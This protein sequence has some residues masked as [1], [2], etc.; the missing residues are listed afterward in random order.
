MTQRTIE[1]YHL[2]TNM[3]TIVVPIQIVSLLV[4]SAS[5]PDSPRTVEDVLLKIMSNMDVQ[6][7]KTSTGNWHC[8]Q[9]VK[10]VDHTLICH[11]RA[12]RSYYQDFRSRSRYLFEYIICLRY[13]IC[14]LKPS[15]KNVFMIIINWLIW[16]H[17]KGYECKW[18]R[19][20]I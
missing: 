16:I 11:F 1:F 18:I 6:A 5:W 4:W 7:V 17:K 8:K 2:M 12:T 9:F 10:I 19:E 13:D 20:S 15:F 14:K 3:M